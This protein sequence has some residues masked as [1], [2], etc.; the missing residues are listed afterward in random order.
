MKLLKLVLMPPLGNPITGE[1]LDADPMGKYCAVIAITDEPSNLSYIGKKPWTPYVL[2]CVQAEWATWCSNDVAAFLMKL[3]G[4]DKA[5][6]LK[7]VI[8]K[9]PSYSN[10]IL[11]SN[12]LVS[13][14][15]S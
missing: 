7:I 3:S 12:A 15:E 9:G 14:A 2:G 6:K 1:W 10:V 11:Y 13:L 4:M 5:E 8:S